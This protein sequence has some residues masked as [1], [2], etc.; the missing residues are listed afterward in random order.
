MGTWSILTLFATIAV[1]WFCLVGNIASQLLL[2]GSLLTPFY[3]SDTFDRP[4]GG[5][6]ELINS[7]MG[8]GIDHPDFQDV[9]LPT[10]AMD[11][12][13]FDM[14]ANL[15]DQIQG[16]R[17]RSSGNSRNHEHGPDTKC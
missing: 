11:P 1:G 14:V 8:L 15:S 12:V 13:D 17:P 10:E 6:A 4:L 7:D 16:P 3:C 5:V 9:F 2:N